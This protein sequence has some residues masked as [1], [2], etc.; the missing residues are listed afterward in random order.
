MTI[1]TILLLEGGTVLVG[2]N[3]LRLLRK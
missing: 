1:P 3:S 2:L